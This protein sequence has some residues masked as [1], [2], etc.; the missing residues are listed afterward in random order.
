LI[1]LGNADL[2]S[3]TDLASHLKRLRKYCF[4]LLANGPDFSFDAIGELR[5]DDAAALIRGITLAEELGFSRW[6]GSVSMVNPAFAAFQRTQPSRQVWA[7]LVDWII[8]HS[9]NPYIPF[10]FC[11]TRWQWESCR[12]GSSSALETWHRVGEM[13][14]N[15]QRAKA[16]RIQR[17]ALEAQQRAYERAKARRERE[18]A[19]RQRSELRS[20]ERLGACLQLESLSAVQKLEYVC[21][22]S[23]YPLDFFPESVALISESDLASISAPLRESLLSRLADRRKGVWKK[24]LT[25]LREP[26]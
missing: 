5:A 26:N 8:V 21:T 13:E 1:G 10:N 11:R 3:P 15:S 7:D 16:E 24:L 17:E 4:F 18:V 20:L 12:S 19:H 22:E 14:L 23:S 25:R 9:T 6:R 2:D